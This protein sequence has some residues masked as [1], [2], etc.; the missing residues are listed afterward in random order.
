[1][2]ASAIGKSC[3]TPT[4]HNERAPIPIWSVDVSPFVNFAAGMS[5]PFHSLGSNFARRDTFG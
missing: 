4:H 2:R 3:I 1:M 5:N